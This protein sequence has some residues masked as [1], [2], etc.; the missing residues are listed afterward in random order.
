MNA[1]E[2]ISGLGQ[3]I[4]D[5]RSF[6]GTAGHSAAGLGLAGPLDRDGLL[7]SDRPIRPMIDPGNPYDA[8][9]PHFEMPAK[10]VLVIYCSGAVSHVDT[11]DYKPALTK[12]HGQKPPGIPAVPPSRNRTDLESEPLRSKS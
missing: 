3:R 8:R 5:G 7:A 9:K 10:Q 4:L 12:L 2:S 11:F 6:L 1:P